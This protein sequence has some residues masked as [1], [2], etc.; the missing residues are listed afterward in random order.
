M[1]VALDIG[2][3][4]LSEHRDRQETGPVFPVEDP[5]VVTIRPPGARLVGKVCARGEIAAER[6]IVLLP[7]EDAPEPF[8]ARPAPEPTV[9]ELVDEANGLQ[10]RRRAD[11]A[12]VTQRFGNGSQRA[13]DLIPPAFERTVHPIDAEMGEKGVRCGV[14]GQDTH[15][16]HQVTDREPERKRPLPKDPVSPSPVDNPDFE[17]AIQPL[18]ENGGRDRE[19]D[20]ARAPLVEAEHGAFP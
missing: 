12:P 4:T 16:G 8:A 20:H 19:L 14:V 1:V 3:E 6:P 15:R 5:A 9:Q 11:P 2:A 17:F 13:G 18:L 7:L 10:R